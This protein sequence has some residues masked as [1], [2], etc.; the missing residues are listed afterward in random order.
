MSQIF[1]RLRLGTDTFPPR[2]SGFSLLLALTPFE[3]APLP[4]G[5]RAM[6]DLVIRALMLSYLHGFVVLQKLQT[7]TGTVGIVFFQSVVNLGSLGILS[8]ST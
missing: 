6:H 1:R 8:K 4:V 5:G 7:H 2:E 3:L